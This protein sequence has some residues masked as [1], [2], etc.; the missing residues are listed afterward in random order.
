MQS[1]G[2]FLRMRHTPWLL[3]GA[4]ATALLVAC[5]SATAT[6]PGE[7]TIRIDSVAGPNAVSGGVT[8]QQWLWATVGPNGCTSF[9]EVRSTR[10]RDTLDLAVIGQRSDATCLSGNA[11]LSGMVL[12]IAPPVGYNFMVIV[13]QPDGSTLVKRIYG[14]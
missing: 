7:F 3:T 6:A 9:K 10:V 4:L 14:E 2:S 8:I 13:H 5:G 11:S 12:N 1:G